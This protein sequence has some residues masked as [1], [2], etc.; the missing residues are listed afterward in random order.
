MPDRIRSVRLRYFRGATGVS[1]ID[2]DPGKPFT[3]LFGENGAGKS[4]IVD[5]IDAVCNDRAGS[6]GERSSTNVR[7][8]LPSADPSAA[9]VAVDAL[10]PARATLDD[11]WVKDGRPGGP[12]Q[13]AAAWA[14]TQVATSVADLRARGERAH[15]GAVVEAGAGTYNTELVALLAEVQRMLAPPSDPKACPVCERPVDAA[16]L[17]GRLA[18]RVTEARSLTEALRASKLTAKQYDDAAAAAGMRAAAARLGDRIQQQIGK[19]QALRVALGQVDARTDELA[20]A[21]RAHHGQRILELLV[22]ESAG[23]T[24]L[25]VATHQRQWLDYV[26]HG[27]VPAANVHTVE[28]HRWSARRGV[29]ASSVKP[30]VDELH[31]LL[32]APKLGRQKVASLGGVLLEHA[33]DALAVMLGV[34]MSR[35]TDRYT[36]GSYSGALCTPLEQ[37]RVKRKPSSTAAP[38]VE[39]ALYPLFAR[40]DG[41]SFVRNEVGCHCDPDGLD[42]PDADVIRFGESTRDLLRAISCAECGA[43]ARKKSNTLGCPC[44]RLTIQRG[45]K[46]AA[47]PVSQV[48]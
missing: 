41:L 42:L 23:L 45:P 22:A 25:T 8:H 10:D 39:I 48:A 3:R 35:G 37:A 5:A 2:F 18:V 13:G 27:A 7:D 14:Q 12:E 19:L 36:L 47:V 11:L 43:M 34:S 9:D 16:G 15:A 44:G 40:V 28:L 29:D 38:S 26:R 46:P 4:S 17:R 32:D 30:S 33:L 24:Q 1:Q 21:R 20:D 6:L 31:T